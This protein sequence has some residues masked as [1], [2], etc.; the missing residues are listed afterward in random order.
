M[1]K[2]VVLGSFVI[3]LALGPWTPQSCI[4][5]PG[6]DVL[7]EL[8]KGLDVPPAPDCGASICPVD[9]GTVCD[10]KWCW[11]PSAIAY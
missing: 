5:S 4:R 11:Q 10:G 8:L 3:G 1:R 2:S 6:S 9:D 7:S